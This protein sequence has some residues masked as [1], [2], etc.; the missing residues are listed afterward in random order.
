LTGV[1]GRRRWW[2]RLISHL[3]S[4][5]WGTKL[6][7]SRLQGWDRS[8]LRLTKGLTT[9]T[10]LLTGYEVILL[11]SIGARSGK[12][13]ITPLLAIEQGVGL[14]LIA[15]NFGSR[16]HPAWYHNLIHH[17]QV[18][19]V[20]HG[21]NRAYRAQELSGEEKNIAWEHAVRHFEGYAAYHDRTQGRQIPVLRLLPVDP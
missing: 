8:F 4:T 16:R 7:A 3:A 1:K 19:V 17:P 20:R 9:A 13:R 5:R 21:E 12:L 18:E 10:T 14:L 15:T 11:R 6:V 2:Q